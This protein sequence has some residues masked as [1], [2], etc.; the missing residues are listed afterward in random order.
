[1]TDGNVVVMDGPGPFYFGRLEGPIELV[2]PADTKAVAI[3]GEI[4]ADETGRRVSVIIPIGD[5][6]AMQLLKLLRSHQRARG[7]PVPD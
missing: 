6:E 4:E 1:M 7:L 5:D 3:R 2:E